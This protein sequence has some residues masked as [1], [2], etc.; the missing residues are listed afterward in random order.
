M[1]GVDRLAATGESVG[2]MRV[3]Q[4]REV[5]RVR[6]VLFCIDSNGRSNR[7]ERI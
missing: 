6:G 7:M 4:P 3:A 5:M 1:W 2:E